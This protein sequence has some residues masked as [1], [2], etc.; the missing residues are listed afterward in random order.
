MRP[1]LLGLALLASSASANIIF[2]WYQPACHLREDTSYTGCLRGQHCNAKGQC[3]VSG[4]VIWPESFT[5][6]K[7]HEA[8]SKLVKRAFSADG[9]CG[10]SFGGLLCDPNSTV[11]QGVCCSQYGELP[12]LMAI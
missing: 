5:N 12:C 6:Y 3:E 9:R 2:T 11:Y 1:S 7:S 8:G 10:P 4:S